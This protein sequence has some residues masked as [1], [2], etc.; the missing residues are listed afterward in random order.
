MTSDHCQKGQF[1]GVSVVFFVL[2]KMKPIFS[3]NELFEGRRR[4][5]ERVRERARDGERDGVR[6]RA[7]DGERER[8]RER[9]ICCMCTGLSNFRCQATKRPYY[10]TFMQLSQVFTYNSNVHL[11]F[12]VSHC[13]HITLQ[14]LMQYG[15]I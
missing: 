4:G 10:T 7:R 1:D 13:S 2:I 8:E 6:E 11:R 5:R 12:M 14:L 15:R 9:G 3:I